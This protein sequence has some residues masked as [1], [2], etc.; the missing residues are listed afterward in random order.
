MQEFLY[1]GGGGESPA[2]FT[3]DGLRSKPSRGT[4]YPI[5]KSKAGVET[6]E[7]DSRPVVFRCS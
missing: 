6:Q 1:H 4:K 7:R 3:T 2:A 5:L